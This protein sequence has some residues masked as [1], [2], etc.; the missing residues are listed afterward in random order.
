MSQT[1]KYLVDNGIPVFGLKV[2]NVKPLG[3]PQ[4]IINVRDVEYENLH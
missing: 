2:G 4:D 1:M 3:T